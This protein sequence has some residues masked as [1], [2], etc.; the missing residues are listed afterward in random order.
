MISKDEREIRLQF[1]EEARE[2]IEQIELK[3]LGLGV[4]QI[5]RQRVDAMLRAAHSIKGGAAM[6][7]YQVL[8]D[9]AHRMEDFFKVIQVK[10]EEVV[11]EELE[12]HLLLG[13]DRLRQITNTY[14]K[15]DEIDRQWL[16]TQVNPIFDKLHD[17]LGDPQVEDSVE[18][19]SEEAGADMKVL[20][21]ES[22]VEGCLQRLQSVLDH[23]EQPCLAEEFTIAAQEFGGL[24]EML[25]L[26][27]FTQLCESIVENLRNNP[28]RT[29]AIAYAAMREW[30]RSQAMVYVGQTENLPTAI[31]ILNSVKKTHL[32][33]S[34]IAIDLTEL[35]NLD[36]DLEEIDDDNWITA[37][38]DTQGQDFLS[39]LKSLEFETETTNPIADFANFDFETEAISAISNFSAE[40][41]S[42]LAETETTNHPVEI[43]P[44]ERSPQISTDRE[45]GNSIRVSVEQLDDLGD[46]FGEITISQNG[47][48]LQLKR[49]RNFI[50][51]LGKRVEALEKSNFLL[52]GA[53]D[54][55]ATE[56]VTSANNRPALLQDAKN[57]LEYGDRFDLL[58]MD[59]YSDLHLLSRELMDTVVQL[60]EVT[61]DIELSLDDT[62]RVSRDLKRSSKLMRKKISDLRMRP[63]SDL[64]APFPRAL[65]QMSLEYGKKVKF[66]VKGES[67][68][69]E[70][71]ILDRLREPLLHLF[72]NAFDHGIEDPQT[73]IAKN[74]PEIGTIEIA[75]TYRSNQT[76]ITITDDGGGIDIAKIRAKALKM[77]FDAEDLDAV[78]ERELLELIFE[79]GF[80]TAAKVTDIS[81]R[82]VGM[83]VVKTNIRA[84]EGQIYVDT[85]PG[86]GT[87][88][89]IVVPFSI[90]VVRVLL[91]ENNGMLMAFPSNAIEEMVVLEPEM[92]VATAGKE[93]V[94]WEGE[95]I[96][97]IELSR[98]LEY[99]QSAKMTVR[100]TNP[101]IDRPIVLMVARGEDLVAIR[102]DRY[103]EEQEVTIRQVE[104]NL[105]K[106]PPGFTGCTILGDGSVVPLIDAIALLRWI[107]SNKS[108]TNFLKDRLN[109]DRGDRSQSELAS[110]LPTHPTVMVVDDSINVRRFV[111][112]I[113][114]KAGYR[115][116]EAKDGQ[117]AIDKILA[118]ANIRAIVCDIEMPVLDGYGF[119]SKIKSNSVYDRIPVIILTSRSGEKHRQLAMNLGAMAYFSKPFREV[120]LIKIVAQAVQ[121]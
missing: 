3:L 71:G 35:D 44:Q 46:L 104:G 96:P 63:L 87:T 1:L 84:I 50:N 51:L 19:L 66:Q 61:G 45:Q 118:G 65:R 20:L 115:V 70:R 9:L 37:D 22:E 24:G 111:S 68:P 82:G 7:N 4:A 55:V 34:E 38:L 93:I 105:L 60:R 16:E 54:R 21:F 67:T 5:D 49:L 108:N 73:R 56:V 109:R 116:E 59:R 114:E 69:I 89:T 10:K 99:P 12:A 119:L 110:R 28:E 39:S 79:P 30:R 14:A 52:R 6:M 17:R 27:A 95:M 94:Q 92:L 26:P 100:E 11:D 62:N 117:D 113:L 64:I 120:E 86:Q 2:Y 72:R 58:E 25:E 33:D 81:G 88:F 85:N 97:L 98:W 74:K 18:M 102:F 53:Y 36:F 13:V 47:L 15:T 112:T 83:D 90:S 107:D 42:S 43:E 75:A 41:I 31:D 77:G 32:V 40:K 78:D 57:I 48:N 29:E 91:V 101:N 23:P 106:M 76:I 103:W 121:N 8:S 80:S